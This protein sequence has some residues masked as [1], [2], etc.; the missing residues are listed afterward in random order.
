MSKKDT[1]NKNF[2]GLSSSEVAAR[3]KEYGLNVFAG[4]KRISPFFAVLKRLNNPL[5]LLII[6]TAAASF[7]LGQRV[8]GSVLI[9]MVT[10][11]TILDFI[12]T[13]KSEKAVEK[14]IAK[15]AITVSVLR[16]GDQKKV[17]VEEVVPGDIVYVVAGNIIPADCEVLESDDFFVNQSALTGEAFPVEKRHNTRSGSK[18]IADVDRE[19]L[20]LMGTSTATGFA[21]LRVIRTGMQTE[22]GKIAGQLSKEE[23]ETDFEKSI[24]KFTL[25]IMRV[26][27]FLVGAVF[28]MNALLGHGWI[29]SF[30]F[31]LAIIIGLTPDLLP[32]I[33]SI[34]LSRGAM[35]MTKKDVIVKNLSS[36]QNFGSMDVLCTDKTGTLTESQ[37]LFAKHV[38]G[39]GASSG[40]VLLYAYLSSIFHTGVE[41]PLD[42][43]IKSHGRL[44][45][46]GFNKVDEIP[47]D[48]HRRRQ[49]LVV[50]HEGKRILITKGAPEA[51]MKI[52]SSYISKNK[53]MHLGHSMM[54][55]LEQRFQALS[56]EGYRVLA[57]A[58][59][60]V[61][62]SGKQYAKDEE[63]QMTFLGFLAFDDP[64]KETAAQS[65][66][67]LCK[68]G[69]EV[70]ILTG[71]NELLTEKVCRDIKLK[72][73][74]IVTGDQIRSL[75]DQ[76]LRD[77][78]LCTTIF[79]RI[80]PE[81][82]E[83][84]VRA[85]RDAGR[86]VGY[87]GDG[88]NDAPSLKAAD[89]G[90]S[91]NNAVDVAKETA[92]II[93]LQKSLHVIKD[94]V[95]EGRKTFRNTMKYVLMGFSSNFGNMFSMMGASAFLPFL[96]MMPT[97]IVLNNFLYDTSQASL[98]GD[99]VDAEE[100]R[101]P[102][103]WDVGFLTKYMITF[104]LVSSV[105]D[106]LTFGVLYLGFH[107]NRSQF[108]TGWF[109]ESIATQVFVIYVIRTKKLPFIQSSPSRGLLINTLVA[110]AVA[111]I[112][113]A[114]VLGSFIGFS[115]LSLPSL[116][117]IGA[118]VVAYLFLVEYIKRLFYRRVGL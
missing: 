101:L 85:L 61:G 39:L 75:S 65:V 79:A 21:T 30:L 50:V 97:Q 34:S 44:D 41:S 33:I 117:T 23:G 28:L 26:E 17:L 116:L 14:L 93:L 53:T 11:A 94:G 35:E 77:L 78:A 90:I 52:C 112:I 63:S 24:K 48:F 118:L 51:V 83:R 40:Q 71:D 62:G 31:S 19:S 5:H 104:G 66:A 67:E 106:F 108:Q 16:D 109:L 56:K 70:K 74:G 81:Q 43:A 114:T 49:S 9:A 107:A 32:A 1:K 45:I 13:Y 103:R 91:V 36:I 42:T 38:D 54:V 60:E 99:E 82:K 10:L 22:F 92:D 100:T 47:F 86:V 2:H 73:K 4:R 18:R 25:F 15:V 55:K 3:Q 80:T 76:R 59:R 20:V 57:L 96:P 68:L 27:L 37:I 98:A 95:I 89:V 69:I 105:F 6:A 84:I 113:P 29:E 111:W 7:L 87:L 110:V 102:I 58:K 46:S 12:D 64:A 115:A 8:S 72:I 88:I